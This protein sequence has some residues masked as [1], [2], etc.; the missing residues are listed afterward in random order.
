MSAAFPDVSSF[1][2]ASSPSS[3]I[4]S[5]PTPSTVPSTT[6]A[7]AAIE[8]RGLT[9][10]FGEVLA[11][12]G[13][14]LTVPRG[15]VF[16]FLGPNG[17]GKTTTIRMLL[18]L[19]RP[20]RGGVEL[21]G[22]TLDRSSRRALLRRVGA[23]VE[24]PSLYDHLTGRGNLDL[25]RRLL[26][27]PRH[28][29]DTVLETVDLVE[30]ADR[31]VAGYSLGMRQRL[32][33]ALA[34]LGEPELLILDEP[35][36]GLD[37][38]GIREMRQLVARLPREHGVTVFLSS[39]LL[40]EVEQVADQLAVL[41][42]GRLL[43]QGPLAELR[44]RQRSRIVVGV[45]RPDEAAVALRRGG[46][47]GAL[48][49]E[50]GLEVLPDLAGG[51]PDAVWTTAAQEINHRLVSQGFRVHRLDCERPSLER[52]FFGMTDSPSIDRAATAV[53]PHHHQEPNHV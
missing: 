41:Q 19:V 33:V 53:P 11:V 6:A 21:F 7:P 38:A 36:N 29:L 17:A 4:P 26:G 50:G 32:G 31:R 51:E 44:A 8:T 37:P 24:M 40:A 48:A 15:G 42:R 23:L 30:A 35:T 9:R 39:H 16:G 20:H 46:L 14:D 27:L 12:D 13:L 25:T 49:V 5:T 52:L 47:A 34:L 43:F 18:G 2:R 1:E 45:D 3:T 28:R 10:R 22:Q